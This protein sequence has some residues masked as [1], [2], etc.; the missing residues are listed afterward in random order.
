MKLILDREDLRPEHKNISCSKTKWEHFDA[1]TQEAI[2]TVDKATF[3]EYDQSN[4]NV[5]RA[6]EWPVLPPLKPEEIMYFAV[7]SPGGDLVQV[8]TF[9]EHDLKRKLSTS[10]W[11]KRNYYLNRYSFPGG[12]TREL[13]P[14]YWPL[15]Q[16]LLI[17]GVVISPDEEEETGD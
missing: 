6:G 12:F 9:P 7:Y 8:D 15:S 2:L 11:G 10:D 4:Y 1:Y 14:T 16:T 5:I 13:D 3:Q 17:R